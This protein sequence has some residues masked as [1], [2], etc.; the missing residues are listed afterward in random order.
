M[1]RKWHVLNRLFS[2]LQFIIAASV[3]G[4]CTGRATHRNGLASILCRASRFP[5]TAAYIQLE[6]F[7]GSAAQAVLGVCYFPNHAERFE[8]SPDG[9]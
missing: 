7:K 4:I 6:Q 2:I 5:R 8:Y 1:P 9:P 3:G